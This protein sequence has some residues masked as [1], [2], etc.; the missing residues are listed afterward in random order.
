MGAREKTSSTVNIRDG[1]SCATEAQHREARTADAE[2]RALDLA[3]ATQVTSRV[4]GDEH[5]EEEEVERIGS[6]DELLGLGSSSSGDAPGLASAQPPPRRFGRGL[7][8]S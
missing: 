4:R 1:R 5:G 7:F 2:A 3:D 8:P 6:K